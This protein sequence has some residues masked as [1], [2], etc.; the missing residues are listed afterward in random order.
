MIS[1]GLWTYADA[2]IKS[3][4]NAAMWTI[5]ALMS[6]PAGFVVY[7]L[8]GRKKP[9]EALGKYQKLLVFCLIFFFFSLVLYFGEYIRIVISS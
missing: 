2:K 1:I 5:I 4:D 6:F 8:A 3:D 9:E 7:L